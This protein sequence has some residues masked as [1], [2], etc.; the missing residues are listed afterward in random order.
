ML[1]EPTNHLDLATKEMLV[2][3]LK[4]DLPDGITVNAVAP[5]FIETQMTAAVPVAT[6][7]VGRAMTA[8]GGNPAQMSWADAQPAMA[9]KAVDGQENPLGIFAAAKLH[10]VSQTNLTLWG[11]VA[12]PLI[13]V[14]NAAT[15]R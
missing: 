14:V 11:Y 6:R 1:D 8:L 13:F 4:D 15:P 10:T 2:D 12:D 3:S 5:G 7:E 9:T